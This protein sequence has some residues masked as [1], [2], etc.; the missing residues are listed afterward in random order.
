VLLRIV[1]GESLGTCFL[2]EVSHVESRKR[3]ILAESPQG[4]IHLD[5]GAV[6]ALTE[7]GTSLLPVGVTAVEGR[8]QRG[9]TVRLLAPNG[10]EVARG[11]A[12]Y[13][14]DSLAAIMGHHSSEIP[15]ILGFQYGPTV[16]HRDDL[17]LV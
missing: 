14:A 15:T 9:Q 10:A 16:V 3:W 8:F 12:H 1:K 13:D 6:E 11:I 5:R 4:A 2:T 7:H 17:V